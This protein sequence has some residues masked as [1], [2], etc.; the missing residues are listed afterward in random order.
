MVDE[1]EVVS[2]C[3]GHCG[4]SSLGQSCVGL[5]EGLVDVHKAI[6]DGLSVRRG[7]RKVGVDHRKHV[8]GNV[9]GREG[10]GEKRER[11]RR[12]RGRRG[13]GEGERRERERGRGG[14]GRAGG[15]RGREERGGKGRGRGGEGEKGRE[16]KG[17]GRE[18]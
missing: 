4:A 3:D 1:V 16:G 9:L 5:M 17:E 2:R 10:E 6:D 8:R 12:G 11:G 13:E 15:E 7:L 18:W 14:R